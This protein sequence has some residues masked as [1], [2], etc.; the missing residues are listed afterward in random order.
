MNADG[1][2]TAT[3]WTPVE[4]VTTDVVAAGMAAALHG[5]LD[6]PGPAPADGEPLPPLWHW[7][8]FLPRVPQRQLGRDGHP[9]TGEF[10]PPVGG[11]RMFAGG[12][13]TFSDHLLVGEPLRRRGNVGAVTEKQGRSGRL[14]FVTVEYGIAPV[15]SDR[16]A[17]AAVSETQDIVYRPESPVGDATP[18]SPSNARSA[19]APA[20]DADGEWDWRLELRP[21]PTMLFR[22]SALT[23][24]AHRIHYDRTYATEE[25]GYPGLVVHGPLQAIMLA[26]LCRRHVPERTITSFQFRAVAPAFDD[27][28]L[29][30]VGRYEEAGRGATLR[31]LDGNA[32]MTMQA[33]V[34]F[35]T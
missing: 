22:F 16:S 14:T 10:L 31:A 35:A 13:T 26:E 2:A 3:A 6:A 19:A 25:E 9:R 1:H 27:H 7:L 5:L 20:P 34:Q 24:N 12:R 29:T 8:A 32:R 17:S 4:E 11:R 18:S 33:D 30:F 21:D 15:N 28:P 23:Y